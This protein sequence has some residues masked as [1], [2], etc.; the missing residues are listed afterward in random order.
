[1]SK[2]VEVRRCECPVDLE[3][4]VD[5]DL[6]TLVIALYCAACSLFP[7]PAE[8]KPRRGRPRKITDN[9]LIC[10]M[11]AQMLLGIPSERRFLPIAAWRLG[12]LF[13]A[14][15]AQTTY[16]ERCRQLAPKLV[17]LWRAIACE[18][19][20][21]HDRLLLLDTTPLPCG[22]S[23]TTVERSELAP[24]CGF[25]YSPAHSRFFWGMRLVLLC[26][27][28]GTVVDFDLVAADTPERRAGLALLER[29]PLQGQLILCDKGFAGREFEQA[30]HQLGAIVLRPSRQDEPTRAHPPTG[31]IR[32]RIESIVQTLKEQLQLER[33]LAKTAAGLFTRIAARVLA[34]C[35]AIHLNWQT[36]RPPRQLITY[37]H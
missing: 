36:G 31:F 33:H 37:R 7:A 26:G 3:A 4:N 15:P 5:A 22:Q 25:G 17:T 9:E 2:G 6:D 11:V 32:Q 16:N 8:R 34:L 13:P 29:Q 24:H 12:H 21:F 23:T 1:L 20:G 18:L 10:L 30:V 14:L 35:A 19:P 27:P 28:D